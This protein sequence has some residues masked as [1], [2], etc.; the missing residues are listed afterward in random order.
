M[1]PFQAIWRYITHTDLYLWGLSLICSG[2]GLVLIFSATRSY[3]TNRYMLVQGFAILL[4]MLAFVIMSLFDLE[5]IFP[6]WPW[7]LGLNVLFQLMLIPFGTDAGGNRSWIVLGPLSLQPAEIGK[8]LFVFTLA[9]HITLVKDNINHWKTIVMLGGHLVLMMG[10]I[11]VTSSDLGMA[12]AYFAIFVITLFAAGLSLKWFAAGTILSIASVPVLWQVLSNYQKLRIMVLFDPAV[13]PE[14]AYQA[15]QSKIAIGAGQMYGTGYLNGNQIQ[16]S[17]LPAKQTD[18]IFSVAGEELGFIGSIA[19]VI[20]LSLLILRL[21]YVSYKAD[22]PFSS[23]L[24]IGIAGMFLFQT[25]ENIFMCL[26][27]FPVMGLTLPFFSYGGSS[28]VTM[29]ATV[30]IAAGVRMREKPS[31]LK[32]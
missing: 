4:G 20:L 6:I 21:F 22:T 5:T 28:V 23:M 3:E 12:L 18:F 10:V 11:M 1:R 26:G 2:Y 32:S 8:L 31:W 7:V 13:D 27:L 19:I 14:R 9:S 16:H 30:G 25:F 17:M 29:F 15:T 24:V